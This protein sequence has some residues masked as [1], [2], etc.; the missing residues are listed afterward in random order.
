[1]LHVVRPPDREHR[2]VWIHVEMMQSQ[3]L[4]VAASNVEQLRN[5]HSLVSDR[6]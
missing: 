3:A 1:L 4:V 2:S 6:L 5:D